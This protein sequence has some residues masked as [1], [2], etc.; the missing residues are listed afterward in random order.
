M[1]LQKFYFFNIKY[2][3]THIFT[4]LLIHYYNNYNCH[5]YTPVLRALNIAALV[6]R[7]RTFN[8]SFLSNFLSVKIYSPT[9]LSF[10]NF[11]VPVPTTHFSIP[12][13][14]HRSSS[15]YINNSPLVR[16]IL[17]VNTDFSSSF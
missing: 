7:L 12:F 9:L 17:T 5:D 10:I 3:P 2:T 8:L 13:H 14:T 16:L 15:N 4:H 6:D 11:K 1:H